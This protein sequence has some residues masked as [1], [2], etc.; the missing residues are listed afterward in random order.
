MQHNQKMWLIAPR[1][2][3]LQFELSHQLVISPLLAQICIN[4]GLI[5]PAIAKRFIDLS[6]ENLYDPYKFKD[7]SKAVNRIEK[8]INNNGKMLIYGDYDVDGITATSLLYLY[9]K[10]RG[11]N[12][13]YYIPDRMEEGYGLNEEVIHWANSE[14]IN[15]IITVDCGISSVKEISLANSL[16]VDII[17]TDHHEP[18]DQLPDA[19][20]I[21]NPKV[22][23]SGYPFS[24]LAGVGVAWKVAQALHLN[25]GLNENGEIV[26]AEYLD[27]VCLGTIADVVP[28]IDENRVIVNLGL[29]AISASTRPGFKALLNI[30]G[31]EN[32]QI[33]AGQVGFLIAPRLNAAG[34]LAS[35]KLAV[36]L[37]TSA[38]G[39]ECITKAT[40]L[41]QQNS[42]RQAVE[43]QIFQ[44]ALE[45]IEKD[46]DL[47]KD[48]VV[49]LA[50]EGWHQGVI[51]IVA[52]R[53]A[54]KI[55]RPVVL[56]SI[57]GETAKGSARSIEGLNIYE[58]FQS[59]AKHLEKFGGHSL[60]AG[61]TINTEE[62]DQ[63]RLAINTYAHKILT[64]EQL[65][66]RVKIDCE[67]EIDGKE[68]ELVEEVEGLAPFGQG[69]PRPVF[70]MRNLSIQDSRAV[71]K[72]GSHLKL[73]LEYGGHVIDAIGFNMA[74]HLAWIS[75]DVNVDVA[76]TLEKNQWNGKTKTQ[77]LLKDIQPYPALTIV[78][79]AISL[80]GSTQKVLQEI[81]EQLDIPPAHYKV[82]KDSGAGRKITAAMTSIQ[83]RAIW[84]GEAA[85]YCAIKGR[86]T[87]VLCSCPS[88][89]WIEHILADAFLSK[90]GITVARGDSAL[91]PQKKES[92]WAAFKSEC[93]KVLITTP[94]FLQ[95]R[96]DYDEILSN[97]NI[98]ISLSDPT[99][100]IWDDH[101][102]VTRCWEILQGSEVGGLSVFTA[103]NS[104]KHHN[105]LMKSFECDEFY[106]EIEP[107]DFQLVDFRGMENRLDYVLNL[108]STGKKCLIYVTHRYQ[109]ADLVEKIRQ[110]SNL[111][112]H[113][114]VGCHGHQL[115][116]QHNLTM[117][118]VGADLVKAVVTT[119]QFG[120]ATVGDFDHVV[121]YHLP[122]NMFDFCH[123]TGGAGTGKETKIHLLYGNHDMEQNEQLLKVYF[124]DR[125][126]LRKLY[127]VTKTLTARG[128]KIE[129]NNKQIFNK[130]KN[131]GLNNWKEVTIDAALTVMMEIGLIKKSIQG[132]VYCLELIET[133]KKHSLETS[134]RY[135]E[136]LRERRAAYFWNNIAMSSD[137]D[138]YIQDYLGWNIKKKG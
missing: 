69:N 133:N 26:L 22:E 73:R 88:Q 59:C 33:G 108:L 8:A 119:R 35:A 92:I 42:D 101:F 34:R 80:E 112:W 122:R 90:L 56:L 117:E 75:S 11:A 116:Q 85:Y 14:N 137:L 7:M 55:Y 67:M 12:V 107:Q 27:L 48:Y 105:Y 15:L 120:G 68:N 63:F 19:N 72:N 74:Q 51:G 97:S 135:Q 95:S 43:A 36:E 1:D 40:V 45:M 111:L 2:Y 53:L 114:V 89:L 30:V 71:G 38:D 66:P 13:D 54:E 86:K 134:L 21:I 44:E 25:A 138:N 77:L 39:N 58:A 126:L 82:L 20:A 47:Q 129:G 110:K 16:G 127:N 5:S 128:V 99:H 131:A 125:D 76:A 87:I 104:N 6:K 96:S 91:S 102:F 94:E 83:S 136:G 130:F 24:A 32:K 10:S 103:S 37:L 64:K 17:I 52:S 46:I 79:P 62:I 115:P 50:S 100:F 18:P 78:Q 57:I 132:N 49:V 113:E 98:V 84:Q 61:L 124:P 123:L 109:V 81:M 29:E 28:L 41:E 4:R 9:L 121:L 70:A 60:A 3:R 65:I 118:M 31:L 23:D 106:N 93:T